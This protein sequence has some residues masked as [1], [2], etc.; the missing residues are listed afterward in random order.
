MNNEI[1]KLNLNYFILF[2][3]KIYTSD[4]KNNI[5]SYFSNLLNI[6]MPK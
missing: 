3:L 5:F 2:K 1:H 6:S 4:K